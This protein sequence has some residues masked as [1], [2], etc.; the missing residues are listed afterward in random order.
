MGRGMGRR[1]GRDHSCLTDTGDAE[2]GESMTALKNP[3]HETFAQEVAKGITKG[4]AYKKAY[5]AHSRGHSSRLTRRADVSQRVRELQTASADDTVL[6]VLERR[7]FFAMVVR[8]PIVEIEETSPLMQG[9]KQTKNSLEIWVPDKV[10]CVAM[11][12]RLAGWGAMG[13]MKDEGGRMNYEGLCPLRNPKHERF[14]QEIVA[15]FSQSEAYRRVYGS[16]N[17]HGSR[18]FWLP[19]VQQRIQQL[20]TP[21]ASSRSTLTLRESR[22]FLARVVR[23]PIGQLDETSVLVQRVKLDWN[24]RIKKIWM[25]N[26]MKCLELDARLAGRE[27]MTNDEW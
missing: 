10:A 21:S 4:K 12:A 15:G 16:H 11:D 23:T 19:N 9:I 26:K 17:N 18:I 1:M 6:T 3:R 25:P 8:T 27:E 2:S 14:A 13:R 24:G 20:Q 22:A 5:G 7:E